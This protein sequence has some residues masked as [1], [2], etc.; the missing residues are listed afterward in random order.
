MRAGSHVEK[1]S[2]VFRVHDR[3]A[4]WFSKWQEPNRPGED[5]A[6]KP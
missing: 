3:L 5:W 1:F 6:A 2:E 4:D